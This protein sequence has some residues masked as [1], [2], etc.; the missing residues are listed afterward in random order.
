M[1]AHGHHLTTGQQF[2]VDVRQVL[3]PFVA[4]WRVV[5]SVADWVGRS[6]VVVLTA[7]VV[8]LIAAGVAVVL[9]FAGQ[10]LW[11]VMTAMVGGTVV[12]MLIAYRAGDPR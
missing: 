6:A 7:L 9:S 2:V 11:S 5:V 10:H 8:G 3:A 12:A 4:V 1:T